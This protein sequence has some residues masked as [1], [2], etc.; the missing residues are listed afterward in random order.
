MFEVTEEKLF[1]KYEWLENLAKSI[2]FNALNEIRDGINMYLD[3]HISTENKHLKS[4]SLILRFLNRHSKR[5]SN[6][7]L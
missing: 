6:V 7:Q 2:L 4:E 5:R 3:G 1:L